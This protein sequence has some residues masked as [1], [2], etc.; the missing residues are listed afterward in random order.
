[1][2]NLRI[3][4]CALIKKDWLEEPCEQGERYILI[5]SGRKT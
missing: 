1:M 3:A 5:Q 4:P 2:G